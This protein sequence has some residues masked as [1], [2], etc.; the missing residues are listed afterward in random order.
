M[1]FVR[2]L[3]SFLALPGVVAGLLPW[4]IVSNDPGRGDGWFWPGLLVLAVGLSVLLWCVRDFYVT[5]KGTLAPWD[6]PK[7]LVRV[8]L[9]GL[10]RNPMYVGVI[11]L[12]SGWSLLTGSRQL[13]IYVLALVV[14][15][16]ARVLL[17]EEPW[18]ARTFPDA[19]QAYR[20][21][22]PRWIPRFSTGRPAVPPGGRR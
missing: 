19:W 10:V 12:V 1:L 20:A 21:A 18:L 2:A 14:L 5:G 6:P 3:A 7:T 13:A 16:H 9:Y 4:M 22:V 17:F 15:F 11:V 8:G